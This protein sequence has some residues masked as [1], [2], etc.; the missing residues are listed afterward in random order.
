M[1][2]RKMLALLFMCAFAF[3]LIGCGNSNENNNNDTNDN[4]NNDSNNNQEIPEIPE[5]VEIK[6]IYTITNNGKVDY[7]IN[8]EFTFDGVRVL[9]NCS[10]GEIRE[11]PSKYI[12]VNSSNFNNLKKGRYQIDVLYKK[13]NI[14]K[15]TYYYVNVKSILDSMEH[16]VGITC[17]SGQSEFKVNED[18]SNDTLKVTATYFDPKANTTRT[19]DVTGKVTI[20]SSKYNKKMVGIYEIILSYKQ[21]YSADGKAQDIEVKTFYNVEV[22]STLLSIKAMPSVYYYD[23]YTVGDDGTFNTPDT[24]NWNIVAIYD[25]VKDPVSLPTSEYTYSIAGDF[26]T[27][28]NSDNYKNSYAVTYSYTYNGQTKTANATIM[29]NAYKNPVYEMDPRVLSLAESYAESS[30]ITDNFKIKAHAGA[31]V[32]VDE[33]A[34]ISYPSPSAIQFEFG[35]RIKLQGNGSIDARSIEMNLGANQTVSAYVMC[36]SSSEECVAGIYAQDGT[37]I[38]ETMVDGV[39]ITKITFKTTTAGLYYLW[40]VGSLNVYYI[41]VTA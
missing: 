26:T 4:Q 36:D 23:A 19:E 40:G 10:D 14:V 28:P 34:K 25:K 2:I 38:S 35:K 22:T 30:A 7:F 13:E 12:T 11:V 33:D 6:N 37:A 15:T 29:N 3:S 31:V 18:F 17:D 27:N 21:S 20:D 16:I 39:N 41:S 5:G 1:K 32:I 9:A 24:S 8:D